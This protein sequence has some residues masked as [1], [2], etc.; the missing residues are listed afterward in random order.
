MTIVPLAFLLALDSFV[1]SK[2]LSLQPVA[3]H[4]YQ[5]QLPLSTS[6][7]DTVE[8]SSRRSLALLPFLA[9]AA[10]T[11]AVALGPAPSQAAVGSLPEL[12]VT[13]AYLQG[14]QIRVADRSQQDAMINFL[15]EGFDCKV[16]RKRIT[17]S[18]EET[19]LGFGPEQVSAP[20]GWIP[21][22]SSFAEYGGHAS[23]AL[24]YDSSSTSVLY[25]LGDAAPGDNIAYLQLAVPGYRISRMVAAGGNIID[26]YG[27]AD[28]VSPSG[29]PIRGIVGIASDPIML[30]AIN[31]VDVA[32]SKSFYEQLG[33]VEREIPYVRPSRGT[34]VFEPAPPAKSVY[35][36]LTPESMGVLLI[37][38]ERRKKSVKVN[39]AVDGLHIVYSP[40]SEGGALATAV[41]PSGVK[42]AFQT[43]TSFQVEEKK[44]R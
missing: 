15:V 36:S 35:L 8:S 19:W 41:D 24:V 30:V 44:T 34:T 13:N 6:D 39:P 20:D 14:I 40:S 3:I 5:S 28:V 32:A 17:G 38:S 43:D 37:P 33:F 22:V 10:T 4:R 2:A 29:L 42:V 21:G 23:I 11:T 26:A 1:I 7:D 31:C 12:A 27:H 9:A 18:V 16:L 25:R